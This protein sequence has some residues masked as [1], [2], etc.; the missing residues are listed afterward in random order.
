MPGTATRQSATKVMLLGSGELGKEVAIECQ[1]LGLEVIAVDRYADAPAMQ[2][3]HR[4]HVISM[5]D[6][7]S[8]EEVIRN[9]KPD[10][11]VPEIEA[12]ATD[13]LV[14][15]EEEGF[16]VVPSARATRLTMD[17][18][19]IRRL[20]A[21]ELGVTTSPYQFADNEQDFRAAV[22]SI[23]YP[24]VVK[25]VMSS[26]GKGQSVVRSEEDI[27][28][29]WEYAQ[30]GGRAGKGKVIVEGFVDF[31][32]E[33][34]LLT[35][36]A[37]DGIHFC[38]PIGHRQEDGDYRESWQPQAMSALALDRAKVIAARVVKAL[39]GYGLFGVEL[40]IKGDEVIFSEVS[41]R[42][43][44]TGMVT[45]ISQEQSEFALHVRAFLGLPIGMIIQ[46]GPSASAVIL[47]EGTSTDIKFS[48]LEL[49]LQ[50][51]GTQLRLFGK[52]D[53]DGRRRLGVAL[54]RAATTDAAVA[55]AVSSAS[56]VDI[57]F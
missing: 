54:A 8:L 7:D 2:V 18:E 6:G 19:G 32:F 21:E 37:K 42:P 9:E 15:L 55:K 23:G 5:L 14:Q 52:P 57:E 3:A 13:R 45:L 16:N 28:A 29:S 41:P 17:R 35:V 56:K 49:A 38:A 26:S 20:A 24:C 31:D 44:D 1:R 40:F 50:E 51:P 4:S 27:T 12:I 30:E 43:H 33:I 39:G 47:G 25:P 34:T 22:D 10:Y 36:S 48:G 11:I 46:H 53:I